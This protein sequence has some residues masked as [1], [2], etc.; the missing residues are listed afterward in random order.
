MERARRVRLRGRGNGRRGS[1][2]ASGLGGHLGSPP[3]GFGDRAI[4]LHLQV[5]VDELGEGS[6]AAALHLLAV[7][8]TH[9]HS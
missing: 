6:A 2:G 1:S 3:T 4:S 7:L 5:D 9:H 8:V